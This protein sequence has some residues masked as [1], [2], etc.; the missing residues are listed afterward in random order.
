VTDLQGYAWLAKRLGVSEATLRSMVS[1]GLVPHIRV[2]PRRVRFDEAEIEAWLEG[3]RV[4]VASP[5]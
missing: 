2:S 4:G 3:R 5:Q 1:R